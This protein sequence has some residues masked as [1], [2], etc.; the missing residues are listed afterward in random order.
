MT[1]HE[2][3][4]AFMADVYGRLTGKAGVCLATL[5]PGA[6]N[7]ITGVADANMDRAPLA[8]ARAMAA[9]RRS[10][11][12]TNREGHADDGGSR[13]PRPQF[14]NRFLGTRRNEY[15]VKAVDLQR[16]RIPPGQSVARPEATRAMEEVTNL[17]KYSG[18]TGHLG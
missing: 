9:R 10:C 17:L 8:A 2:Q 6:T 5:G 7:L 16:V 1:R 13:P 18:V 11:A 4:A 15:A 3:G 14:L 12:G